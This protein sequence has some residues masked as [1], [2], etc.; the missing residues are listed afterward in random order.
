MLKTP[1]PASDEETEDYE[2]DEINND[3][4]GFI[5]DANG[6]LKSILMPEDYD[7]IPE[8]IIEVFK[9]FGITDLNEI[10]LRLGHTLH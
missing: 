1:Y 8:K 2:L 10:H 5:L 7:E 3:D 6:D 4:Y 9:M